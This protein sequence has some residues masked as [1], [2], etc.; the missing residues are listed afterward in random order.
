MSTNR[1]SLTERN[2][3]VNIPGILDLDVGGTR[4]KTPDENSLVSVLTG[5]GRTRVRA[6]F[7]DVDDSKR[8]L[9]KSIGSA[10][11]RTIEA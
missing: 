2:T 4:Q 1:G 8:D 5:G 10:R 7:V 6:P 3:Q 11:V 9:G